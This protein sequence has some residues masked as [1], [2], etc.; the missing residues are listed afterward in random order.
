M[1][2]FK[3]WFASVTAVI[4]M[5]AALFVYTTGS[6]NGALK[7]ANDALSI[8]IQTITEENKDLRRQKNNYA[9]EIENSNTLFSENEEEN[10]VLEGLYTQLKLCETTLSE[11]NTEL[12]EAKAEKAALAMYQSNI[13]QVSNNST[14]DSIA[15]EAKA[16][17]IPE[18]IS[19][20]RYRISGLGSFRVV[21]IASGLNLESQNLKNLESNTYTLNL[22]QATKLITDGDIV[23]TPVN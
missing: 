6:E 10:A 18:D 19:A 5:I 9:A 8:E 13:D 1:D 2:S 20:G 12:T 4:S 17:Q 3:I 16:Y 23:I 21:D 15:L 14:G 11:L 22:S 7:Y